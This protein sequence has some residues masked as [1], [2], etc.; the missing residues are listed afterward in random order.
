M[1]LVSLSLQSQNLWSSLSIYLFRNPSALKQDVHRWVESAAFL[2]TG[3][4]RC[5]S[6][7]KH[8][9]AQNKRAMFKSDPAVQ[10]FNGTTMTRTTKEPQPQVLRGSPSSINSPVTH[11]SI[12]RNPHPQQP[13]FTKR[14]F[15]WGIHNTAKHPT[16]FY[17]H[18]A[19]RPDYHPEHYHHT[20]KTAP[21]IAPSQPPHPTCNHS[22]GF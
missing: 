19:C 4:T 6:I 12:G 17:L 2:Q 21:S 8:Q 9:T 7:Y 3:E 18:T 22:S 16:T 14:F 15:R 1:A 13:P 20:R 5:A 11:I 10:D